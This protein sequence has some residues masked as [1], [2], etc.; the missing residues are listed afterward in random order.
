MTE[1]LDDQYLDYLQQLVG[2]QGDRVRTTH[3]HLLNQLFSREFISLVPNDDNREADGM[4]LRREFVSMEKV[5]PRPSRTWMYMGCSVL[6]MMIGVTRHLA[7]QAEGE[8]AE[9]FWI[10]IDNLGLSWYS[11]GRWNGRKIDAIVERL[12][13]RQYSYDGTGGLF[14]LQRP[15][16]DQRKVEIWSQMEAFILEL[17]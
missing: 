5:R 11:D 14:P 17:D 7:F 6:E 13:W 9:W 12:V 10:L 8:P 1:T 15:R 16:E 3:F 2:P 4:A